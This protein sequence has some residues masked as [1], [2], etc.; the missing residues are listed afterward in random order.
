MNRSRKKKTS[1]QEWLKIWQK[2]GRNLSSSNI[3]DIINIK[4]LKANE[5]KILTVQITKLIN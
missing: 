1:S 3:D 5:R 2:Q 4:I